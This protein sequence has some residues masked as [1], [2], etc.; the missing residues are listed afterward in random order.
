MLQTLI[1]IA[2]AMLMVASARE[3]VSE[4]R[5]KNQMTTILIT[6]P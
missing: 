5:T 4:D 3:D 2:R 1:T 6:S